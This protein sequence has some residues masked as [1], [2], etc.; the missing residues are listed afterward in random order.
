MAA[1]RWFV[2]PE[3]SWPDVWRS[4]ALRAL[5]LVALVVAVGVLNRDSRTIGA[6]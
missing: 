4:G 6:S 1:A 5:F 3:Y 2:D